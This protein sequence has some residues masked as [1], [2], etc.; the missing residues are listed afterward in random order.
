MN[1]ILNTLQPT[2][3]VMEDC[4]YDFD[5]IIRIAR[6]SEYEL[7]IIDM[8]IYTGTLK[9]DRLAMNDISRYFMNGCIESRVRPEHYW[10]YI[11]DQ[12]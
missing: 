10:E 8:H 5:R 6:L 11:F 3:E 4:L 1:T 12:I 7:K 9:L 2:T